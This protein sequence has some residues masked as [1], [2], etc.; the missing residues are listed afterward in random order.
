MLREVVKKPKQLFYGHAD[1]KGVYGQVDRKG[2]GQ[3]PPSLTISIWE[4]F[5][6]FFI[7]YNSLILKTDFVSL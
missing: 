5:G 2:G 1:R 3:P 6:P 4:N 7:E